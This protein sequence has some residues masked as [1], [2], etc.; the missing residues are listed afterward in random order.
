MN[1]V[2]EI[3]DYDCVGD[4]LGKYNYNF[5][6]IDTNICKI[7]SLFFL[8]NPNIYTEFTD[9]VNI[10]SALITVGNAYNIVSIYKEMFTAVSLLSSYWNTP[11]ISVQYPTN[12]I[13][14]SNISLKNY[15][16][17]SGTPNISSDG[18][19]TNLISV[20]QIYINRNFPVS[21]Y[22]T[23][24]I[25]NISFLLYSNNGN[26]ITTVNGP[27]KNYPI[28]QK[29]NVNFIKNDVY[30]AHSP[31]FKFEKVSN[32]WVNTKIIRNDIYNI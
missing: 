21:E 23:G 5:L 18:S 19:N 3:N 2:Y 30:V 11:E 27:F 29:W 13:S 28:S 24:S 6:N 22:L 8:D 12:F 16:L 25:V 9:F 26:F 7:S 20:A 15:Y 14:D 4:S 1:Y 10:S 32:V 17:Y 31:I